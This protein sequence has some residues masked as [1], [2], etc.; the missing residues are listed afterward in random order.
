MM[1]YGRRFVFLCCVVMLARIAGLAQ[2]AGGFNSQVEAKVFAELNQAREEAGAPPLRLDA[3]L[4]EAARRHSLLLEQNQKLSHQ[5][6]GEPALSARLRAAGVYFTQ[7]AENAGVNSDPDNIT[8][9]FVA[10]PGHRVNMLNPA[11]N[12]VG[13]GVVQSG[14]SYWVTEDFAEE[15]PPVSSDEAAAEAAAAFEAKWSRMHPEPLKRVRVA[16]LHSMACGTA[17]GGKLQGKPVSLGTQQARQVFAFSTAKPSLLSPQVDTA[18]DVPHLQMYAVA[19]CT[20]QES[21]DNG[22]FWILMAFF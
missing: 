9:M 16:G 18:L 4:T 13:I 3:N 5:F 17:A 10:S 8:A 6:P 2:N 12:S 19:A 14:R 22:H 15:M 21:G 11:Y 20:P 1:A 7:S